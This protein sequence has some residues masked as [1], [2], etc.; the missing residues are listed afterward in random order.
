MSN[1]NQIIRSK[2]E[3]VGLCDGFASEMM[4][5]AALGGDLWNSQHWWVSGDGV[6]KVVVLHLL[7]VIGIWLLGLFRVWPKGFWWLVGSLDVTVLNDMF[8]DISFDLGFLVWWW[9]GRERERELNK[10]NK[11]GKF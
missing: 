11:K 3:L 10:L 7:V 4:E 8:D 1:F 2:Q 6:S 5:A 9:L